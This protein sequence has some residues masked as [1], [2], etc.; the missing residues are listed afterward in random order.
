MARPDERSDLFSVDGP[1]SLDPVSQVLVPPEERRRQKIRK[2]L[3]AIFAL[4]LLALTAWA[5][6]HFWHRH[7]V[8]TTAERA[9]ATGR[10]ADVRAAL[11]ALDSGELPGLRA[12]LLAMLALEGE[13][14]IEDAEAAQAAV[15]DDDA[16]AASE[17]LKASVYIAL[18]KGENAAA[19]EA[20]NRLISAGDFAAETAHA[21]SLAQIAN[22]VDGTAEAATAAQ[23]LDGPR[24]Q[25]HHAVSLLRAGDIDGALSAVE[26]AE[27]PAGVLARAR[28][29]AAAHR[30]G[31]VDAA[32]AVVADDAATRTERAWAQ[33][34]LAASRAERGDR[35]GTRTHATEALELGGALPAIRW[36]VAEALADAG[37]T[38]EAAA[39]IEGAST[40]TPVADPAQRGRV[41]ASLALARGD[42][43]EAL[44]LMGSVPA[45]PAALLLVGDAR[46]A[47]DEAD[48]ARA[49]YDAAAENEAYVGLARA[50]RADLEL[51]EGEDETALAQARLAL[52]ADPTH[53]YVAAVV[54]HA[55]LANDQGEEAMG[56]VDAA[57]ADSPDDVRLLA[58]K[59]HVLLA[60]EDWEEAL[61]V[62]R[63]AVERDDADP[64]LQA[65]LGDAARGAERWDEASAAYT[66]ALEIDESF[67]P[68]LR[69][70]FQLQVT[71]HALDDAATTWEK[72]D[73]IDHGV[74]LESA[75]SRVRFL[76][77]VGAGDDAMRELTRL[78]RF[79]GLRRNAEVRFAMAE[80]L[81]QQENYNRA[82][83]MFGRARQLGG[84]DVRAWLGMALA[85]VY[86]ARMNRATDALREAA[87]ASIPADAP[88]G[89][90]PPARDMPRYL[91]V[92]GWIEANLGR[93]ASAK[94][95]AERAL[96]ADAG[97]TEAQVLL[98]KVATR[99]RQDPEPH[100]RAAIDGA[101]R[102]PLAEALLALRLGPTEE[103][104][105]LARS[106]VD[107][108]PRGEQ[109]ED[110]G[111]LI[112]RCEEASRA[113][114]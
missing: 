10:T 59:A 28:A 7:S 21:K 19:L 78:S 83:A 1:P 84:D 50:R 75:R 20:A 43:A 51:A 5:V 97:N 46:R 40:D 60:A 63:R 65:E 2:I 55:M 113:A 29:L 32:E 42:A 70:L 110:A 80:N 114:E 73:A 74:D 77:D 4:I 81:L 30:E 72:L 92:R 33:S 15:P 52:A 69:G 106:Y 62:L 68:A 8:E 61:N 37:A 27:G 45:S 47:A 88:E 104:C 16:H 85:Q 22:G 57:L 39:A 25:A 102:R 24:H 17:K 14:S 6:R 41:L 79:R 38:R 99:S 89:A 94:T 18:S 71:T 109:A 54:A 107:A 36:A 9:G 11:D 100:W 98:A 91:V 13:G 111:N 31:A 66:K 49:G 87:D 58:A 23:V 101:P 35:A 103:G 112:E 12:R 96:E 56:V 82:F 86:A 44:R 105:A 108:A 53:P 3:L 93:F 67:L 48:A 76:V 64:E 26:G 95:Y 34:V 90:E